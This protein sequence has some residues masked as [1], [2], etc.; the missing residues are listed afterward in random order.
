MT[1]MASDSAPAIIS[2]SSHVARGSVGNRASSFA[3][4]TLG[5]PT[6]TVPTVILPFHPGHGLATRIET[7]ARQFA[8]LL[9]DLANSPWTGEIAAIMTGYMANTGQ[10]EAT[11][12]LVE[13]FRTINPD[14]L[15]LCDPVIGDDNGLY[16]PEKI[17]IAIRDHLL[18]LASIATPN[19]HELS[20]LAGSA[21]H[22]DFGDIQ[23]AAA[24]LAN[25]MHELYD[26]NPAIM[27]AT[28]T[29]AMMRGN[30]GTMLVHGQKVVLAENRRLQG[31]RN[32]AGDLFSALF[33]AAL[34]Q[35]RTP[36]QAL[37]RATASVFEVMVAA[38]N[39][40]DS[41][42][43]PQLA[44]RSLARPMALITMRHLPAMSGSGR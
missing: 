33:L 27:V 17:A 4:E 25:D 37:E 39:R 29:P 9:E 23:S 12:A 22:A 30:I 35:N 1:S 14:L 38:A 21:N 31:P 40:N 34:L 26:S 18:P 16:V 8:G 24:R 43:T 20:W 11:C 36:E 7:D 28:S 44:A 32:G 42:L 3:F 13:R 2:I 15:Y 41:E 5:F 6:W 10:I 19:V